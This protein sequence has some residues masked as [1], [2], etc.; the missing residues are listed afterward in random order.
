MLFDSLDKLKRNSIMSA[1]LLIALGAI[2][3]ICP[4]EYIPSLMLLFGYS[5]IIIGI[6]MMLTFF[7]GNKSLMEYVKFGVSL[8]FFIIGLCVI[9]F[10]GDVMK[11][12]AWMFGFLLFADGCR[13]AFHSFT[14]ARRSQRKYWW[15]LT[16]LSAILMV[17]GVV[18]FIN[19][20]WGD[21][22]SLM[23]TIGYTIFFSAIVSAVRLFWTWPV[24]N[25]KGADKDGE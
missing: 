24:N 4:D 25:S 18:L 21:P 10:R 12:L 11:M 6:V 2:V 3:I 9:I 19:P 23:K 5:L 8:I 14:Y 22:T 7:S 17:L 16:I 15:I 20:W 1:I 13:T